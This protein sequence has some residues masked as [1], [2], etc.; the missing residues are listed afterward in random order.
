MA[1][2]TGY[3]Q[4]IFISYAQVD[5]TLEN[6]NG[7]EIRWV[8]HLKEQLQKRVDQM[9]GRIGDTRIWM[10]LA[11]LAGNES[12]TPAIDAAIRETAT[13]V[14]VLSAGYL[15]STWCQKE[16]QSFA[17]SARAAD[18]LFVVHLADIPLENRPEAIRDVIGF[19]FF[20]KD[21]KAELDPSSI[22]YSNELFKL[23]EKLAV[24]LTEMQKA[25][26]RAEANGHATPAAAPTPAV[27]LAE[28]ALDLDD[29]RDGL[30]TYI[31]KLGYRILPAKVYPRGARE[32]AEMLDPDL[33]Q[34]K[35]FVQLLGQ[36]GTRRTDDFP[37]GY[38]GLQF[39]HAQAAGLPTLRAYERDTV[40]FKTIKNESYRDFLQA[41]DVMAQDLEEFKAAIKA[42]LKELALREAKPAAPSMGDHPVLI[43]ACGNDMGAA[44][45]VRDRLVSQSLP[46]E[47]VDDSEP[48]EEM[49]KLQDYAALVLVF[50]EQSSGKWI[51]QG[52]RKFMDLRLSRQPAEPVC[53]LYFDPPEKRHQMLASPPP[54]FLT[55]D[56]GNAESEFQRFFTELRS[57]SAA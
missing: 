50:G 25:P 32:F 8:S 4:D 12:V 7:K 34:A 23:R 18:R 5:N 52:M 13:L 26:V 3:E 29:D 6:R 24:K 28:G 21:V 48:L 10:D 51:K 31:E 35:L 1:F 42:K 49:A 44:F 54:F 11:D 14:I 22:E 20:D 45:H 33:A 47:I 2:V 38:E 56:S 16:I 39:N 15:K 9:L 17:K 40:D 43:H 36:L 55:I 57:T 37:E 30:G 46:Y 27:Y 41:S 53:A 19:D